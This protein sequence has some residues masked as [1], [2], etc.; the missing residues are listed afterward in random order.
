MKFPI[1]KKGV[2]SQKVFSFIGI[3][4]ISNPGSGLLYGVGDDAKYIVDS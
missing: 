3:P 2:S 4:W 1:Q